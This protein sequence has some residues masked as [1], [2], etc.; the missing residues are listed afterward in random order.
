MFMCCCLFKEKC[1]HNTKQVCDAFAKA[2]E[3]ALAFPIAVVFTTAGLL[4]L[5]SDHRVSMY[6]KTN[7]P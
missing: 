7:T 6:K 2:P 4:T 1:G 3:N 5:V